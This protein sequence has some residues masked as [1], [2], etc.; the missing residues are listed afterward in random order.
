M[1]KIKSPFVS[2]KKYEALEKKLEN[3]RGRII[4]HEPIGQLEVEPWHFTDGRL[5]YHD[6]R[7]GWV[8]RKEF[9]TYTEYSEYTKSR[10][11]EWMKNHVWN[12]KNWQPLRKQQ[13]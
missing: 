12:G 3:E 2:R 1:A 9:S 10:G 7:V 11:A 6:R 13:G 4:V 8:E 5:C